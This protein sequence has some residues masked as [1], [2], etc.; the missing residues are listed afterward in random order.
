MPYVHTPFPDLADK[1][2]NPVSAFFLWAS[3]ASRE[4]IK[5]CPETERNR[6]IMTGVFVFLTSLFAFCTATYAFFAVFK[7]L[8]IAALGGF[9]WA[10]LILNLD[11]FLV[12]TTT[13]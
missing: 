6:L 9:L 11:R 1:S 10:C 4:I 8:Q 2:S 12:S 7:D 13:L 3:G 5:K